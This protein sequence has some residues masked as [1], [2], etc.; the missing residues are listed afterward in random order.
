MLIEEIDDDIPIAYSIIRSRMARGD[1][2]LFASDDPEI[3]R[4]K[5]PDT[6]P[7]KVPDPA[8]YRGTLGIIKNFTIEYHTPKPGKT[9]AKPKSIKQDRFSFDVRYWEMN[10]R[11]VVST[12]E[13]FTRVSMA[14]LEDCV[15][16][17][18]GSGWFLQ[19]PNYLKYGG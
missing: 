12:D 2:I 17:P 16:T 14:E 7:R 18:H 8:K 15:L 5:N 4:P 11:G 3:E 9:K 6:S 10:K 13:Q 19:L 1:Q